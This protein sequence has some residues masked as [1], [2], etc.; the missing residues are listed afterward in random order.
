M[1]LAARAGVAKLADARDSKSRSAQTEC[2]F[3]PR[4][5]HHLPTS[6]G[7]IFGGRF[8]FVDV[9]L[10]QLAVL[11]AQPRQ[12]FAFG[13][14]HSTRLAS[15]PIVGADLTLPDPSGSDLMARPAPRERGTCSALAA[16]PAACPITR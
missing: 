3:D 1:L 7:V 9:A 10:Q 14:R 12:L 11:L 15:G 16:L 6:C 2:G 8:R 13:R 4:L 5:R